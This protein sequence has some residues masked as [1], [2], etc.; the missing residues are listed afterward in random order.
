MPETDA[1]HE[2]GADPFWQYCLNGYDISHQ[3]YA[4]L[5]ADEK[6]LWEGPDEPSQVWVRDL[7]GR[8]VRQA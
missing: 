2:G 4:E 6:R 5:D 3:M 7:Q 8:W 1:W